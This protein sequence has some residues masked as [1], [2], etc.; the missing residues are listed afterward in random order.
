MIREELCFKTAASKHTKKKGEET[1]TSR[2][3]IMWTLILLLLLA[4]CLQPEKSLQTNEKNKATLNK[5]ATSSS[6]S[7]TV[8]HS[9]LPKV[10]EIYFTAYPGVIPDV[11][12]DDFLDGQIDWIIGPSRS[13]LYQLVARAKTLKAG[14]E[15]GGDRR[16]GKSAAVIVVSAKKKEVNL[17]V[18]MHVT[19]IEELS[20]MLK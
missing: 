11:I 12:M 8:H 16:G 2:K 9:G 14:S 13:D 19:P 15:M 17:R 4:T 20:H 18:D 10:D 1:T 5:N 7:T 6:A 3:T